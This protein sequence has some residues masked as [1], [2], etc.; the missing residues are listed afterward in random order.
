MSESIVEW[1]NVF[2]L[3]SSKHNDDNNNNDSNPNSVM[4][5]KDNLNISTL[6]SVLNSHH[7]LEDSEECIHEKMNDLK[8]LRCQL[9]TIFETTFKR[10]EYN[11]AKKMLPLILSACVTRSSEKEK[12]IGQIMSLSE[13]AQASLMEIIQEVMEK[14]PLSQQDYEDDVNNHSIISNNDN[15]FISDDEE[16]NSNNNTNSSSSSGSSSTNATKLRRLSLL[17]ISSISTPRNNAGDFSSTPCTPESKV[18]ARRYKRENI[19]LIE[20]NNALKIHIEHLESQIKNNVSHKTDFNN[21]KEQ[22]RTKWETKIATMENEMT[23]KYNSDMLE[24]SKQIQKLEKKMENQSELLEELKHVKDELECTKA[25]ANKVTKAEANLLKYKKKIDELNNGRKK[26]KS[27]EDRIVTL[28][29]RVAKAENKCNEIPILETTLLEYKNDLNESELQNSEL[30]ES[31]KLLKEEIYELKEENKK[32]NMMKLN[33]NENDNYNNNNNNNRQQQEDEEEDEYVVATAQN[34]NVSE[35]NP[36]IMEKIQKLEFENAKLK[37]S[38][39]QFDSTKFLNLE[40]NLESTTRLKSSFEER[41]HKIKKQ[42]H[43][44]EKSY[45]ETIET[46][47]VEKKQLLSENV[48]LK[49]LIDHTKSEMEL[50]KKKHEEI[51]VKVK[52]INEETFKNTTETMQKEFDAKL[53]ESKKNIEDFSNS[54]EELKKQNIKLEKYVKLGKASLQKREDKLKKFNLML[55]KGKKALDRAKETIETETIGR[56]KAEQKNKLLKAENKALIEKTTTFT[57]GN[58]KA[59]ENELERVLSENNRLQ[60]TIMKLRKEKGKF[61]LSDFEDNTGHGY[62]LINTKMLEN[63]NAKLKQELQ[64]LSNLK[65]TNM[66]KSIRDSHHLEKKTSDLVKECKNLKNKNVHLKL[67]LERLMNHTNA[68][69]TGISPNSSV[70]PN[71]CSDDSKGSPLPVSPLRKKKASSSRVTKS[72]KENGKSFARMSSRGGPARIL[73]RSKRV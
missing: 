48:A 18:K 35:L 73:T 33:T 8:Y 10:T 23:K 72:N 56:K 29:D 32:Q 2:L 3:S 68:R 70:S 43:D 57:M 41:Y 5:A 24:K 22:I 62:E 17:S 7:L 46:I 37:E 52:K 42:L 51:I 64:A 60:E 45:Q 9:E 31:V 55:Q 49:E 16:E 21:E 39:N 28:L 30:R 13:S 63:E 34:E 50:Q 59:L 67:K 27:M 4:D 20:E 69:N 58:M 61:K 65:A 1:L 12:C 53:L 14:F 47:Q 15:S 66:L 54:I 44:T 26:M 38:M 36:Q 40:R 71:S 25:I 11:T 19:A 6:I